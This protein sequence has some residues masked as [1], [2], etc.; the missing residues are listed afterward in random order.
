MPNLFLKKV[1]KIAEKHFT[2]SKKNDMI[3]S[4]NS[5][6]GTIVISKKD[7]YFINNKCYIYLMIF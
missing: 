3:K 5:R 2:N 7:S 4:L 1:V 6:E